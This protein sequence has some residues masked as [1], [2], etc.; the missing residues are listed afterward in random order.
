MGEGRFRFRVGKA[1]QKKKGPLN[2]KTLQQIFGIF[3]LRCG[4]MAP[5]H[6]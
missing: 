2:P 1:K 3:R 4:T 5:Q 6:K